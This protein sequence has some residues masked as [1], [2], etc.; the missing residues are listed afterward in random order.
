MYLLHQGQQELR[1]D[2]ADLRAEWRASTWSVV[3]REQLDRPIWPGRWEVRLGTVLVLLAA[4]VAL[5]GSDRVWGAL[6]D[7]LSPAGVAP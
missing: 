1:S 5:F 3:V 4:L 6:P 2:L 7:W